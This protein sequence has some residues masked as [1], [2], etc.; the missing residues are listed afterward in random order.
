MKVFRKKPSANSPEKKNPNARPPEKKYPRLRRWII[1]LIA[2]VL[3][4]TLFL[5][6]HDNRLTVQRYT[7][8]TDKIEGTIRVVMVSDLH[9]ATFG[10]N[11]EDLIR[12]IKREGPDVVVFVGDMCDNWETRECAEDIFREITPLYP[13]YYVTGNHEYWTGRSAE[14][15]ALF[16]RY[17]LTVLMGE[18]DLFTVNGQTIRLCGIADAA[19]PGYTENGRTTEQQLEE[20]AATLSADMF[21]LLLAHRPEFFEAYTKYD[22]DLVLSGH[23]HGGQIRIPGL[24]NGLYAP[25]QGWFPKYA[26]G[27]YEGNGTVMIVGRGLANNGGAVPRIFNPPE[28][29]VVDIEGAE[30]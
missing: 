3:L 18:S 25:N 20:L 16:E 24:I 26:G 1:L 21:T 8:V 7:V 15:V 22:F 5:C 29:V 14:I 10:E 28:L 6:A 13:C 17:D 9:S 23:A 27:R 30:V 11:E 2:S 12:A 19:A 4:L